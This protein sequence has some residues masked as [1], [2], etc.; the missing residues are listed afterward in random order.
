MS[1]DKIKCPKC[2]KEFERTTCNCCWITCY[3]CDVKMCGNCG[4]ENIIDI[5]FTMTDDEA[6]YWCCEKCKD[7]GQEGCRM[8]I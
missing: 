7:C 8:C 3:D 5:S 2:G 1:D 6:A 4:S